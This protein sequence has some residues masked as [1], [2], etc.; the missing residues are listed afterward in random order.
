MSPADGKWGLQFSKW[1]GIGGKY[2]K[3]LKSCAPKHKDK[4]FR[5]IFYNNFIFRALNQSW[6]IA[7][8]KVMFAG[9]GIWRREV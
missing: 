6:G 8:K 7:I 9:A 2:Q 1:A 5:G 3:N 4:K